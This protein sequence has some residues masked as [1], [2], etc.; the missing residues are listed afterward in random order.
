MASLQSALRFP[1]PR[2]SA[3]GPPAP[4]IEPLRPHLPQELGA[5]PK[6]VDLDRTEGESE[7][8]GDLVVGHLLREAQQQNPAVGRAQPCNGA[9]EKPAGLPGQGAE[10]RILRRQIGRQLGGLVIAGEGSVEG[11]RFEPPRRSSSSALLCAIL[12]IQLENRR[13][14]SNRASAF[15]ALRK[16]SCARSSASSGWRTMRTIRA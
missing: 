7:N 9:L 12:K 11:D 2:V 15:Q 14:G 13:S 8:L 10:Q 6:N 3:P 1:R 16:V 5:R 4:R